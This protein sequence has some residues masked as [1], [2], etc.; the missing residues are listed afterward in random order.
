MDRFALGPVARTKPGR[1]SHGERQRVELAMVLVGEPWLVLLDEPAAG[2]SASD[3]ERMTEII[4]DINR[5]SAV[6]IIEHDMQFIRSIADTVTVFHRG[7]VLVEDHVD[8]V[9][10]NP[11]VRKVYL[12]KKA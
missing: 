9:M 3:I 2:M 1:L 5:N 6:I 12:G 4:H 8:S 7:A 11:Q 10:S